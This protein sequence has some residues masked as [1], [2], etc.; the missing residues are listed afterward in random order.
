MTQRRKDSSTAEKLEKRKILI[1]PEWT[2]AE[3]SAEKWVRMSVSCSRC[4][5]CSCRSVL[6]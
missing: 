4:S 6:A 1:W 3:V 5:L 2:E